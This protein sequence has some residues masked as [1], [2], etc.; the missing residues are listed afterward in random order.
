M[1]KSIKS[2]FKKYNITIEDSKEKF[3]WIYI[4]DNKT[5]YVIS[6]LGYIIS[7]NFH[8]RIKTPIILN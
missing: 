8:H 4:D 6:S 2:L 1:N 5:D 3:K 7:F